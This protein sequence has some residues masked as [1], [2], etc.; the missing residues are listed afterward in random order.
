MTYSQSVWTTEYKS[1]NLSDVDMFKVPKAPQNTNDVTENE[2]T[3]VE[4]IA[5]K[6][7]NSFKNSLMKS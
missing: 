4:V 3:I 5:D 1:L 6:L 2:F 7:T